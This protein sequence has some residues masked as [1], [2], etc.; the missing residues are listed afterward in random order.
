MYTTN[1]TA[2][3]PAVA[4]VTDTGEGQL[5]LTFADG[6]KITLHSRQLTEEI[7]A[8]ALLHGLKQK[9]VDA[10]A[11]SRDPETG[12][13][14]TL[15]DKKAAVMEVFDRILAGQWNKGREGGGDGVGRASL[16]FLALQRLQPNKPAAAIEAWLAARTDE[17]KAGLRKNPQIV[18]QVAEI[19]AERAAKA[20]EM[21]GENGEDLLAG[22]LGDGDTM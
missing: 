17:E 21:G 20:A 10:A 19:K 4:A 8:Q 16:L 7:R 1:T 14:A 3:I 12:R 5:H 9:L 15:A 18:R 6:D 13:S 2:R 22:F 11:I